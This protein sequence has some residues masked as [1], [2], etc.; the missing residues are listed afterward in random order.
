V[1]YQPASDTAP[2]VRVEISDR[3]LPARMTAS[4]YRADLRGASMPRVRRSNRLA[5]AMV[6]VLAL[7][8]VPMLT[9]A[10]GRNAA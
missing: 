8:A 3:R 10:R 5:G 9:I 6:A 7:I 4:R 2:A 1:T